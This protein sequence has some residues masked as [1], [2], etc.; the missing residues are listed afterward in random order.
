MK[1]AIYRGYA[2]LFI[3]MALIALWSAS[4]V[5]L[6]LWD[7]KD[8]P[9]YL[10]P[11]AM[12]WMT[13]LYTGLFITAHDAMHNNVVHGKRKLN[14]IVGGISLFLYAAFDMSHLKDKHMAHHRS[15]ATEDDP[16]Y[17]KGGRSD[18]FRWYIKFMGNY[19]SF[20]QLFR[21]SIIF[22]L[23]LLVL[24][25]H[26]A[27][28]LLFW[29]APAFLSTFQLFYFGT[30]LPHKEPKGG[31]DNEHRA[32]SSKLPT[33]LTFL[34]CYNFG[35]HREHHE[36]PYVPWWRLPRFRYGKEAKS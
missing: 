10:I 14:D 31:Y 24:R 25:V 23:L 20:F 26:I 8:G 36:M 16:D 11:V 9:Y 6:L 28:I 35:I 30:Y 29:I 7:L 19:L 2:G 18:P 5:L 4:L 34:A 12:A 33:F 17:Y 22:I 3:A 27:N 1:D 21:M 15:P 13:F 32:S